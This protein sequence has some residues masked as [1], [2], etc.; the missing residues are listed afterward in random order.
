MSVCTKCGANTLNICWDISI[1]NKWIK[2]VKT[3][4]NSPKLRREETNTKILHRSEDL[5]ILCVRTQVATSLNVSFACVCM[6]GCI[7]VNDNVL[8]CL[9]VFMH[10][11][12]NVCAPTVSVC[13]CVCLHAHEQWRP[14]GCRGGNWWMGCLKSRI[15]M[16]KREDPEG[17]LHTIVIKAL[18]VSSPLTNG[19]KK[20]PLTACLLNSLTSVWQRPPERG[21]QGGRAT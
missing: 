12:H 18:I 3:C 2:M 15:W 13:V 16:K 9:G 7:C 4:L 11:L 14:C 6:Q 17:I 21:W 19:L 8:A 5:Y 20:E 1:W 10:T